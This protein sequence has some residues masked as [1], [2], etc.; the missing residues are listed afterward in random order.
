MVNIWGDR[1]S[2]RTTEIRNALDEELELELV[3]RKH[4]FIPEKELE[5]FRRKVELH[6][7]GRLSDEQVVKLCYDL[8]GWI[9]YE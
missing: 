2:S 3:E 1:Y 9:Y 7:V 6:K 4:D 5:A 8:C